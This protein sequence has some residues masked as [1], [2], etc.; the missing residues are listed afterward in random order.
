[1][2]YELFISLRYLK[3]KRKQTFISLIS[4][5]SVG[6][7]ALGVAALIA[8]LA[9]MTG[10]ENDVREKILGIM[11]HVLIQ[12]TESRDISSLE[13]EGILAQLDDFPEILT[14]SPYVAGQIMISAGGNVSGITV[15]G[16]TPDPD[17]APPTLEEANMP[18]GSLE[19]LHNKYDN[20]G[21]PTGPQ[22]D[23][24]I[25]GGQV[26]R[27]LGVF[28]GDDVTLISPT[29]HM[30][31]TG[32]APK[33]KKFRVV[34]TFNSGFYPYDGGQAYISLT[35]AQK[36]FSMR[37]SLSGLE[38]R[39]RDVFRSKTLAKT[40]AAA[41]GSEYHI[42]DWSD[43][44]KS[45]FS[46]IGLEKL[47]M[48]LIAALITLVAAFNIV[49][50]LVMMV[51]EK[52]ADIATLKSMGATSSSIMKIFMLEG[53]VIGIIG[54]CIGTVLGLVGCWAADTFHLI[55]LDSGSYFLQ[56]LP[57]TATR[58]DVG[59]VIIASLF[60]CFISTLYP[61]RQA[62]KLDPVVVFRYE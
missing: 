24:I 34:S 47:A 26:A 21:T 18:D 36:F 42:E 11:P 51:M 50:T 22:R 2:S 59:I 13:L 40:L 25:L 7:V 57:F 19:L 8:V 15:Y 41:L 9:V 38:V 35:A 33:L 61:A 10:V 39:V 55:R 6:G 48:F 37:D 31:P 3:A 5:I 16:I 58:I 43:M 46:A 62:S 28:P 30:L 12:K 49:S 4:V 45:L 32:L 29:G 23:G 1:M 27:L 52:Q 17:L 14:R 20:L 54:T 60:I 56:Y 53:I 44:N